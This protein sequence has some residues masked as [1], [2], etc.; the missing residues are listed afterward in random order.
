MFNQA[1]GAHVRQRS[2]GPEGV[3]FP[4]F[5]Q[6]SSVPLLLGDAFAMAMIIVAIDG[7]HLLQMAGSVF[8]TGLLV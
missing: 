1:V 2:Q 4:S 3:L 6:G 5:G 8:V 7:P